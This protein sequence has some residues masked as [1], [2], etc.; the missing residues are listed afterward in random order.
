ML[1]ICTGSFLLL[2]HTKKVLKGHS[3]GEH[4]RYV[5]V[6]FFLQEELHH[7]EKC[8][9]K[10]NNYPKWLSKQ[11]L[12]LLKPATKTMTT[13]LITKKQPYEYK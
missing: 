4:M 5:Q 6:I 11:R 9:T 1:Y 7:T 13:R 2:L 3:L 10:I 8:F 12:I